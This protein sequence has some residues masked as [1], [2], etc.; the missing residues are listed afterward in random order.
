MTNPT[1]HT[2]PDCGYVWE[3]GKHGGHSCVTRLLAEIAR[4]KRG[5]FTPLEIQDFCHKLPETVTPRQFTDGC[6]EYQRKLFGYAPDHG[7]AERW[8]ALIGCRRVRLLGYARGG[9][10]GHDGPIRHIGFEFTTDGPWPDGYDHGVA[11]LIEFADD[12]AKLPKR[13]KRD[14]GK[15]DRRTGLASKS[16]WDRRERRGGTDR[17]ST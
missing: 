11:M 14:T 5:D 3:H 10:K 6:S 2:C 12:V 16:L 15:P 7:D 8:R 9:P 4:L 1:H 17:R 13:R